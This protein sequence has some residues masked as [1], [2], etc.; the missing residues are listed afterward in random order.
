MSTAYTLNT[1][2]S[3]ADLARFK[4]TGSKIVVA[5]PS[6]GGHPNVAWIVFHPS[7]SNSMEWTEEY[8]IYASGVE[9]VHGAVLTQMSS[10]AIPTI[11]GK[12]YEFADGFFSPPTTGGAEG[13]FYALNSYVNPD[14]HRGYLTFGLYQDAK[15][16][17]K[18]I[19]GNAISAATVLFKSTAQMTPYTTIYL[20][21]QSEVQSNTVLTLVTS[22]MTKV[23]FGGGITEVSLDYDPEKGTFIPAA[24]VELPEGIT[25]DH[26]EPLAGLTPAH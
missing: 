25:L 17:T 6:D 14:D 18:V 22:P 5:K 9:R 21:V 20:W 24:S 15:V 4:A 12:I 1:N 7:E 16:N 19:K 11:D 3:D 13:S 26:P 2:F 23:E 8:G 10:T